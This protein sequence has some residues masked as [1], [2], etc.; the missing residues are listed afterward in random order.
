M[1]QGGKLEMHS[2]DEAALGGRPV[3]DAP[4]GGTGR[5]AVEVVHHPGLG[6]GELDRRQVDHVAQIRSERS[7]EDSWNAV[8]PGVWPGAG[9]ASIPGTTSPAPTIR[10]RSP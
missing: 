10:T 8:W 1:T 7:P 4:T 6:P 5:L 9:I 2:C 3:E